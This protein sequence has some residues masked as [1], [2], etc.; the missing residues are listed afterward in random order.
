MPRFDKAQCP[1]FCNSGSALWNHFDPPSSP[2]LRVDKAQH[3][4]VLHCGTALFP[5]HHPCTGWTRPSVLWFCT[6]E[7][8]WSPVITHAQ[9]GQGPASSMLWLWFRTV[10]PLWTPVITYAQ[11]GQGPVTLH[12]LCFDSGS[13]L[14]N[15]FFPRHWPCIGLTRPSIPY[16]VILVPHCGTTLFPHHWPCLGDDRAQCPLCC[17]SGSTLWNYN[18]EG[19]CSVPHLHFR[20]GNNNKRSNNWCEKELGT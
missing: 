9:G 15:H 10:E 1:L 17:D 16:V 20:L 11:G 18:V 8:L 19:A 14:W 6:A 13:A 7:P 2:M 3:P 12:P 5:R 4:L